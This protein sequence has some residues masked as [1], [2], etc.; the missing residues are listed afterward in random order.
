MQMNTLY[1]GD[2]L[3]I[4]RQKLKEESI[5][6]IYLDPPFNSKRNYNMMYK[7]MTGYPVSEQEEAFC[8]T[9]TLDAEKEEKIRNMKIL[10]KQY[11]VDDAYVAFW[12]TWIKA[13]RN[14]QPSLLAYLV[15]M[16]E[17][18]L[19]MRVLL[20]PTGSIYLHCDPTASHYIKVMMDGIF[21]HQNFRNE[22][23]W[24]YQTGG[25]SKK[26]FSKKH[27]ALLFY[28]K[29][30]NYYFNSSI[31]K[32]RRTEKSLKRAQNHNGAR[33]TADNVTKLPMDVW[34]D[35]QALNP[36][37]RE[38]LGYPTQKPIALLDRIIKVSCPPDGVIFDPFCGCGTT[39]YSAIKNQRKW[40]GCDIAILPVK[41]I[42]HQLE[43]KYRLVEQTH[44]KID[45]IP[46]SFEQAETLMKSSPHQFQ[47]WAIEHVKGFPTKKKSGDKGID[48]RIFIETREGVK[49]MILSVKGGKTIAPS[50]IRELRGTLERENNAVLAGF[51]SLHEP[52][53]GMR[54]EAAQAG[55]WEYNGVHY[56]RIQ[57]LSV[58]E[59]FEDEKVFHTPT[60]IGF[61][62]KTGQMNLPI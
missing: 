12:S 57:L 35:I 11:E 2:N 62:G 50:A 54:E 18:L 34:S 1:Y 27:D 3:D 52:T 7:T 10:M 13:L 29:G 25:A 33:Y 4:M 58:K 45:G 21:G 19:Q 61:K 46:V 48:G 15:Y 14:T 31:E 20:K 53:K 59:F 23:I 42:K 6:L 16:V 38:R 5:D 43:E 55:M 51:I 41:L 22:I 24:H 49:D 37:A 30:K 9:W 28:S 26:W 39:I 36:M 60:K 47:N 8:D 56:E 17:R 32:I 44:F 40:I